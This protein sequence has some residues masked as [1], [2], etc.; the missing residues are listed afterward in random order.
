MFVGQVEYYLCIVWYVF[1]FVQVVDQVG[2]LYQLFEMF[3]V[4]EYDFLWIEV[5][6]YFFEGWLFGVYQVVFEVGVEDLQ[7]DQ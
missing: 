7:V 4:Y 1:E 6:E 5:E 3:G 2:V